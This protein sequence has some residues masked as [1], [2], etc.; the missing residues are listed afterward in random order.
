MSYLLSMRRPVWRRTEA[1]CRR[2]KPVTCCYQFFR[3][4]VPAR[5]EGILLDVAEREGLDDVSAGLH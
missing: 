3:D 4:T 5:V 1:I 2:Y